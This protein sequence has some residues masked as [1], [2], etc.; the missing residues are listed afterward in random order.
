[1]LDYAQ[2]LGDDRAR[3]TDVLRETL[4]R[5]DMLFSFGGIGATPDDHTRQAAAAALGVPLALHPEAVREIEARFGAEAYPHRVLMAEFPA[6]AASSPIRSTASRRSRC[7][8]I[9]SSRAFRRWRGRCSTGCSS[10][11]C[12]ILRASRR[13][14]AR[15]VVHDAGES[16]LLPL[17]EAVTAGIP[18]VKLFS[19]PTLLPDDVRGIE[20]GVRGSPRGG[21]AARSPRCARVWS[22][23]A[24]LGAAVGVGAR[25]PAARRAAA[26]ACCAPWAAR[27]RCSSARGC[28]ARWHCGPPVRSCCGSSIGVVAFEPA[29]ATRS[30]DA[31]G[32]PHGAASYAGVAIFVVLL[33]V[34]L[35]V[36]TA[37]VA[38]RCS[39]CPRSCA[40]VATA[41]ISPTL[42][43]ASRRHVRR[44]HAQ[45]R[46]C[47][48][49]VRAGVARWRLLLLRCRRSTWSCRGC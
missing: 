47:A 29:D 8:T 4:A 45:P 35:A 6:G 30:P 20:L 32:E 13:S 19:L 49:A 25:R 15:V 2:Y 16:Q 40:L 33:F 36:L 26:R 21:R 41:R 12:R 10:N 27:C 46:R 42:E 7:A 24:S 3:L 34:V 44:Q 11:G 14:S 5:G 17:M 48:R 22:R 37:L 31:L 39:R 9:I 1:M 28:S 23:R 43:R 38:M 18:R